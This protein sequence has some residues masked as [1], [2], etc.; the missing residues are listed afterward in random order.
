MKFV[1]L[2]HDRSS[3]GWKL[4]MEEFVVV[5]SFPQNEMQL[6][7][8]CWILLAIAQGKYFSTKNSVKLGKSSCGIHGSHGS[9]R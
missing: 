3:N 1:P 4:D 7:H 9:M 6:L 5:L 2:Q 8:S